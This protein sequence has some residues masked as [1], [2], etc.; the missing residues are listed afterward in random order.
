MEFAEELTGSLRVNGHGHD[1]R[2][3]SRV[4]LADALHERLGLTGGARRKRWS[5]WRLIILR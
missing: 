3:K 2:P 4:T 1:L 5:E